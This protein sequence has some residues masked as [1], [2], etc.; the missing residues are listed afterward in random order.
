MFI[1]ESYSAETNSFVIHD[2]VCNFNIPTSNYEKFLMAFYKEYAARSEDPIQNLAKYVWYNRSS[3]Y[4]KLNIAEVIKQSN[5]F[6]DFYL[7]KHPTVQSEVKACIQRYG[8][9]L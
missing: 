6:I 5:Y 3:S 1:K 2:T 4:G 7:S 9:L 8:N